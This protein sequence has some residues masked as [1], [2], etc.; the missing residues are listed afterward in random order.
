MAKK[1]IFSSGGFDIS[2]NQENREQPL[3]FRYGP[4][5]SVVDAT[6]VIANPY[7]SRVFY[8]LTVG[9]YVFDEQDPSKKVGIDEYWWQPK[10]VW[11]ETQNRWIDGFVLKYPANTPTTVP[12]RTDYPG[13]V[14]G[15][16]DDENN[17]GATWRDDN[18]EQEWNDLNGS[19]DHSEIVNSEEP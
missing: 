10:A 19:G 13:K 14:L 6:Y 8:G 15:L 18:A 9:V 7:S 11:D 1:I 4:W 17:Y 3:D 12:D 2:G 16:S 5:N